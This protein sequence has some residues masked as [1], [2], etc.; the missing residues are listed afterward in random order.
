M[1]QLNPH[2]LTDAWWQHLI[3]LLVS[4]VIGY[5]ISYQYRK[6]LIDNLEN[7]LSMLQVDLE[8][9]RKNVI[10]PSAAFRVRRD[11]KPDDFK[12]IEGV[13]PGIER[14]LYRAGIRTYEQLSTFSPAAI[15]NILTAAGPHFSMHDPGTWPGQAALAFAG[16]WKELQQWQEKLDGGVE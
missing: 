8:K 12:I 11:E 14:V 1:F 10:R 9:C 3:I 15:K 4:G 6:A 16:K 13:G 2:G 7:K 5:I